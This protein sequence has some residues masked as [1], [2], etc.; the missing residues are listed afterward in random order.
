LLL[1]PK[2]LDHVNKI[3]YVD[4]MSI[5]EY[6]RND[7]GV[8]LRSGLEIPE[9]LTIDSLAEWYKV[10]FTPV[11]T[12]IAGLIDDGLLTKASNHRLV[13]SD[14]PAVSGGA[15]PQGDLPVLPTPPRDHYEVIASDLVRASLEGKALYLREEVTADKYEISRS[16]IRNIFHR[17]AGEGM[18]DHIPRRGWRLRVFSQSELQAYVEVREALELKALH[19]AFPKVEAAPLQQ[20]LEANRLP[21]T[22]TELPVIDESLHKYLIELSGNRYIKD[23]FAKQGRYFGLLF[24]WEDHDRETAIETVR[25]HHA[26]LTNLLNGDEKGTQAALS[27]HILNNHPILSQIPCSETEDRTSP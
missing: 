20:M 15:T 3:N 1:A 22:A 12:A 19:L 13:V 27:Y 14:P 9:P 5:A 26:I 11:R 21:R 24:E 25:Q 6:I 23:F 4:A 7:L 8:R 10:S 17:L 16:A 2:L 18:L